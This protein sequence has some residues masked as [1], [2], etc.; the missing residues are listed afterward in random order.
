MVEMAGVG[1]MVEVVAHELARASENSLRA[2]D[3]LKGD[4]L[5]PALRSHLST[6]KAEMK[7]ISK[8]V[9]VLDP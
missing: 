3:R 9:R 5:P 8:R 4:S 6:F 1:L 2:L 7:S